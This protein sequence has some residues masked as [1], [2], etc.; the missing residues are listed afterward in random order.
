MT[1]S[2][3][4]NVVYHVTTMN[5]WQAIFDEQLEALGANRHIKAL[6]VTVGATTDGSLATATEVLA[7]LRTRLPGVPSIPMAC[8]PDAYEHTALTMV[9]DL[10]RA[11]RAAVLYF[12]MKGVS[13]SPPR[14]L[15][16]N[17]RRYLNDFIAR[18]DQWA[19]FLSREPY[20]ACGPLLLHDE[21][22]G[23]TYFAG[24]FWLAR[25]E[26]LR[27]LP[28]YAHFIRA[29]GLKTF[30]P[31]SRH[32]AEVAVNRTGRMRGYAT[33]GTSLTRNVD[34]PT[35]LAIRQCVE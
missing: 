12:H 33:D 1:P 26:Y 10:A 29:P 2:P 30:S 31:G 22:H 28:R 8:R 32:L 18:A 35:A 14:P 15:M 3:T 27:E 9:D 11:D 16:E 4:Y 23:I 21:S 7:G 5:H 17:W 34:T 13:Y 25:A 24:N 20:D 6:Y 19:D